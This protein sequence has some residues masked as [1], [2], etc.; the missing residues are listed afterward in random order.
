M[1]KSQKNFKC[2]EVEKAEVNTSMNRKI[3]KIL[4]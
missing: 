3:F 2:K 4:Q 1:K